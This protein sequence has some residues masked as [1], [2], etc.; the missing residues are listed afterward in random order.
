MVFV[1]LPPDKWELW[2][3][4]KCAQ[5][6]AGSGCSALFERAADRIRRHV[7]I[8]DAPGLLV[9]PCAQGHRPSCAA[10]ALLQSASLESTAALARVCL[11]KPFTSN[12]CYAAASLLSYS[13][14]EKRQAVSCLALAVLFCN[15]DPP[16][17]PW[18]HRYRVRACIYGGFCR[19]PT[20]EAPHEQTE[21]TDEPS[22]Q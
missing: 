15:A 1:G 21:A 5:D 8:D 14:N 16:D 19:D 2:T 4:D 7:D 22:I 20:E 18:A 13:C 3:Q 6:P 10:L 17:F 9:L 12:E 11:P